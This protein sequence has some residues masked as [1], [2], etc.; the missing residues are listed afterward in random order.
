MTGAPGLAICVRAIA[1]SAS[2][3]LSVSAP[4]TVIGAIAPIRVNGVTIVNCPCRAKSISP[5]AIGTSIWR[6]EFVFTIV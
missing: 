5:R 2:A 3:W 6:G 1:A 4:A